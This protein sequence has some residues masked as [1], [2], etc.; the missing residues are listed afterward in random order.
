M[1]PV[2]LTASIITVVQ[3]TAGVISCLEDFKNAPKDRAKCATE[4]S[5]LSHLL[6]ILR[7]RLEEG[8]RSNDAW[9]S[10]VLALDEN[11][12]EGLFN[13]YKRALEEFNEKTKTERKSNVGQFLH[14]NRVKGDVKEII[15][16]IERLKSLV[17]VALE[18][19]HL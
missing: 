10:E 6:T 3:L 8:K 14:W 9:Y 5:N 15:L 1:E 2:G 18:M 7:Y 13:Q 11:T 16:R 12:E 19:D 17:L 4:A